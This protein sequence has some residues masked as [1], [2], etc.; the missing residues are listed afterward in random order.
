M[1][2]FMQSLYNIVTKWQPAMY[3]LVAIALVVIGVMC[4]IP[5]QKTKEKG[6]AALPWVVIGCGLVL[7]AVV[8]AKEISSAFVF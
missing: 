4:I 3:I 2:A 8:L 5:S 6:I 7:G 1:Q